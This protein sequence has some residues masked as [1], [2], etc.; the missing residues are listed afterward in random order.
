MKIGQY[1]ENKLGKV[2]AEEV[3]DEEVE[4]EIANMLK[5]ASTFEEVDEKSKLGSV[6]NIDFEGF[7][8]GVAFDGGK[9]EGYDLELGS[10]TFIPGFEDQLVGYKKGDNVDVNVTF[11][12][13]YQAENL[14]GKPALFKC[15]I[16]A[17]KE[18]KT[19]VLN[20]E[21]VAQYGMKTV[22]DFKKELK[23]QMYL[24]KENKMLNDY[25]TKLLDHIVENSEI[26]VSEEEYSKKMQDMIDYYDRAMAQYGSNIDGYLQMINSTMED[27]KKEIKPEAIKSFKIDVIFD[28]VA[29][30]ENIIVTDEELNSQVALMK[31]QY[32]LTQEQID[33]TLASHKE[34]MKKDIARNKVSEF[35][36]KNND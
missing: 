16:N 5:Q 30:L 8:D 11:P 4:L 13:N 26:E 34:D 12:E 32:N 20:E 36:V 9:G 14:K 22:E 35:L 6:V 3:K 24:Q 1:K 33:A 23:N 7:C 17:V 29:K 27:F 2:H 19:A 31:A 10:N 28:E 25:L 18:K 15:K 21:F